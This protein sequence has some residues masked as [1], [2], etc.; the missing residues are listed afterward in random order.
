MANVSKIK[1]P[2]NDEYVLKDNSN[3]HSAHKHYQHEL[4]PLMSHTYTDIIA[5]SNDHRGAGFFGL[6]LIPNSW[7][8]LWKIKVKFTVNVPNDDLYYTTSIF[9]TWGRADAINGYVCINQIASTS[10]RPYYYNS[11][12]LTSA[13]GLQNNCGHW[14]GFN[15]ISSANPT[16]TNLMRTA[17]IEVLAYE[18]CSVE[19]SDT[20]YTPDTIP[21]RA[22]QTNWYTSTVTSYSN[23]STATNGIMSSGDQ[24]TT[25]TINLY[26]DYT[27]AHFIADQLI[28]RYKLVFSVDQDHITPLDVSNN[29]IATTK[30]LSTTTEFDPFLPIY[31][32]Y[33]SS[34]IAQNA[35]A[36]RSILLYSYQG[37]DLRYSFNITTSEFTAGSL[38]YLKI[39]LNKG[40]GKATIASTDPLTQELPASKDGYYYLVLGSAYDGYRISLYPWHDI[41][42]HNGTQITR[43]NQTFT[44]DDR[45]T[46]LLHDEIIGTL[47]EIN[48]NNT[49][50]SSDEANFLH[51]KIYS[52]CVKEGLSDKYWPIL[53]LN[54]HRWFNFYQAWS[55]PWYMDEI[56][57]YL[58]Q[59]NVLSYRD[60]ELKNGETTPGLWLQSRYGIPMGEFDAPEA[61][62]YLVDT[63]QS[64]TTFNFTT[65]ATVQSMAQG[66]YQF[67]TDVA[68]PAGTQLMLEKYTEGSTSIWR[69]LAYEGIG[70]N[71]L[72]GTFNCSTGN[73]GTALGNINNLSNQNLKPGC[74]INEIPSGTSFVINHITI[75]QWGNSRWDQSA[76]RQYLNSTAINW[77][78]PQNIFDRPPTLYTNK[79]G[80]LRGMPIE[81]L[82][83]VKPIKVVTALGNLW[84]EPSVTTYDRFFLPS[85]SHEYIYGAETIEG[86]VLEYWKQILRRNTSIAMNNDT[87]ENLVR[88]MIT[89]TATKIEPLGYRTPN[90]DQGYRICA[91]RANSTTTNT[92][93]CNTAVKSCPVCVVT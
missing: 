66:T 10:Y 49:Y 5:T 55:E 74:T 44:V 77:W 4:I 68:L 51:H 84:D 26:H 41:Y 80:F 89:N 69:I 45:N 37:C 7:D 31:Y 86:E 83:I 54:K 24:N 67:T 58:Y 14:I 43:Y 93:N 6:K 90:L 39:N 20:L 60:V 12:F 87:E 40:T 46:L 17:T 75:S 62:V 82:S 88:T 47:G 33:S 15:L 63:F 85:A 9:E 22:E 30:T 64:G 42:Y 73:T 50:L 25:N 36:G 56:T 71:E 21:N 35:K 34:T 53:E 59:Q 78:K 2:S 28:G 18:N 16:N 27:N 19:F 11:V 61:L 65:T 23:Y 79:P 81:F 48:L 76:I 13:L 52:Q 92:K 72:L 29:V 1:L 38:V 57:D 32:F 91:I 70:T 8:Q 3:E